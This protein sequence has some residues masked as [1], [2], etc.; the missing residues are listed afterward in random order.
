MWEKN[1]TIQ[2]LAEVRDAFIFQCFTGFAFQDVYGLTGDNIIKVGLKGELW[3]S[4]ERGKTGVSEIGPIMPIAAEII[5]KYATTLA[6]S[7]MGFY[8]Q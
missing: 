3:L 6:E 4:K 7:T 2:R 8:C 1:I 5:D